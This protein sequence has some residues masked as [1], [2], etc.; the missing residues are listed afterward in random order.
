MASQSLR[1]RRQVTATAQ[2]KSSQLIVSNQINEITVLYSCSNHRLIT[3]AC[4]NGTMLQ[5]MSVNF[6]RTNQP[7][8]ILHIRQVTR[9]DVSRHIEHPQPQ[10]IS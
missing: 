4:E 8:V 3:A 10:S 1:D 9:E 2:V 6:S 5:F 7:L